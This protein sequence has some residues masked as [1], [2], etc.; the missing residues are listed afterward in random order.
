MSWKR[1]SN[2]RYKGSD[3]NEDSENSTGFH[4][5]LDFDERFGFTNIDQM[6]ESM[7]GAVRDSVDKQETHVGSYYGYSIVTGPDGRPH[8]LEF[9]NV[10]PTSRGTF[11]RSSREPFV[12]TVVD[13]KENKLKI[14]AEMP[15]VQR[16]DIKLEVLEESLNI[17]ADHGDRQYETRV[18][19]KVQVEPNTASATYNN[20]V[21]EV[22]LKLKA[23][24]KSK[25]FS[26]R[27]D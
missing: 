25:G 17:R 3:D 20:G 4:G 9:G 7:F 16:E 26:V 10:K 18:P 15:G 14:I 12:D 6:I 13:D 24:P 21:L 1:K 8:V 11:E 23:Q 19:I 22:N 2:R 5:F 27:V